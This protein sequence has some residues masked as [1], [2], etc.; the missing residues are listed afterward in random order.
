MAN[1]ITTGDFPQ[2]L[3][4]G[5]E[6]LEIG[7]KNAQKKSLYP[8]FT[9][10]GTATKLITRKTNYENMGPVSAMVEG[11]THPAMTFSEGY[12]LAMTAHTWGGKVVITKAMKHYDQRDL[13]AKLLARLRKG[14]LEAK[15]ILGTSYLEY[16]ATAIASVPRVAGRPIVNSICGDGLT[17]FNDAHTWRSGGVTWDNN[18][19][20]TLDLVESSISTIYAAA[21]GWTDDR[22]YPL[23]VELDDIIFPRTM[24]Q[25]YDKL[26]LSPK[27]PA[28][29]NN[30]I[31]AALEVLKRGG[32]ENQLLSS[33]TTWYMLTKCEG[34]GIDWLVGW[35]D[36][37]E[38]PEVADKDTKNIII[39]VDFSLAT[40]CLD[41][42]RYYRAA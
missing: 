37:V 18:D 14:T 6:M 7:L 15:E 36:E 22:G 40:G 5:V 31:N 26:T 32:I 42:H 17:I 19:A 38:G 9:N 34:S 10:R 25:K 3:E 41:P 12:S 20:S 24:R 21:R 27:E 16:G 13:V 28:T 33:T 39:T 30:A 11:G 1:P 35:D 23:N 29:G 8:R 4:D 2:F